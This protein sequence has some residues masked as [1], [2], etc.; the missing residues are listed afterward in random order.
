MY[1]IDNI[2][3]KIVMEWDILARKAYWRAQWWKENDLK[4]DEFIAHLLGAL[5]FIQT[6]VEKLEFAIKFIKHEEKSYI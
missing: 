2:I 3:I 4:A 5:W 1:R 6:E